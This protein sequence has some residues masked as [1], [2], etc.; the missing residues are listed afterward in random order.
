MG[1][2]RGEKGQITI[3]LGSTGGQLRVIEG[4]MTFNFT[5]KNECTLGNDEHPPIF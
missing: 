1:S 3:R 5:E 4:K 2:D